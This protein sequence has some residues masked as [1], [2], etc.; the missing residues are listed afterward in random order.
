L[1]PIPLRNVYY[2]LCYAWNHVQEAELVDVGQQDFRRMP[3]L[4]GHV[5]ATAAARLV[6]RGLDRSYVPEESAVSGIKGKLDIG[7]TIRHRT[8]TTGRT[9]CRYDEFQH[10]ILPNQILK[11][12]MGL[13]LG[14][15][16]LD[17]GVRD[18]LRGV[19]LHLGGVSEIRL[20]R[21]HFNRV[22]IH[23]NNRLYHFVLQICRLIFD[24]VLVDERSGTSRFHDFL[25]DDARMGQVFEDFVYNFYEREQS[26]DDVS[27]PH[28]AWHG[29]EGT[30]RDLRHL[31]IM[32]TDVVLQNRER[33]LVMDTKYYAEALKGRF[34]TEKVRSGHLYQVFSYLENLRPDAST[35]LEGMLLYPANAE[36]FM[37]DY[38]LKGY[39]IRVGTLDL[40]QDWPIIH[41]D[42]LAL[43]RS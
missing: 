19:H 18:H 13:L 11:A 30:E 27:R 2:L 4:L 24:C 25:D 17:T 6:S 34:G 7:R 22:Q 26:D 29:Q 15:P 31:P 32:R 9:Y 12:T 5:L 10:D 35:R 1:S 23:R 3:D 14:V 8:M 40:S 42:L 28:I 36:R 16:D 39:R 37:L 38:R 43:L 33:K 41:H 21:G 20:E